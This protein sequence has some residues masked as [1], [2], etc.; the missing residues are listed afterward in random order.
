MDTR[1]VL[2]VGLVE[3]SMSAKISYEDS[4]GRT[5]TTLVRLGQRLVV[6]SSFSA[7][8]VLGNTA[9]VVSEHAELF[10]KNEE[11][12]IRNLT[13]N[14][15]AVLVN[16]QSI[17]KLVLADGDYIEIGS[18]R[19]VISI[20]KQNPQPKNPA[21]SSL[22][23]GQAVANIG[24]S[25]VSESSDGPVVEAVE[26]ER[27]E[28]HGNVSILTVENFCESIFPLLEPAES[29]WVCH[30][31]C[32]HLRSGSESDKPDARNFLEGSP[33]EIAEEND[34]FLLPV[35]GREDLDAGWGSYVDKDAGV[36]TI[37]ESGE[38]ENAVDEQQF[39]FLSA[40]FMIPSTLKFH[41]INGSP[42]L[43]EKIFGLFDFL[44]ISSGGDGTQIVTNDSS[45]DSFEN[46]LD[47]IKGTKE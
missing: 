42:L 10:L 21:R 9:G 8:I 13:G 15:D 24:G 16:G 27:F 36:I 18:N 47:R 17:S 34:L 5:Q 33:P 2:A 14:V 30:L 19:L 25:E 1:H 43:L 45:I 41:L 39:Q 31:I 40:W 12:S 22:A 23:E 11:F 20:E 29:P 28:R 7:D 44:V 46:F 3:N 37:N 35:Q 32:N 4:R 26:K 38:K 6:G